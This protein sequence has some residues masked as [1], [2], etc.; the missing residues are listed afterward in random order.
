MA[1]FTTSVIS[2]R[3]PAEAFAYMADLRNFASWDPGVDSVKQR[4]GEGGG[5]DAVFDVKVK[6]PGGGTTLRYVTTRHD[7]PNELL[8]RAE[9]KVFTS[10]DRVRVEP[11]PDGSLVT[12]E[13]DLTMNGLLNLFELPLKLVFQRIGGRAAAGLVTALDGRKA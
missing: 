1:H 9:S 13:A 3:T 8:V 6:A 12:Y 2:P 10:V 5:L 4:V 7:A 11:H